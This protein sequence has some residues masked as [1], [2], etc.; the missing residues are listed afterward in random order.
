MEVSAGVIT[1]GEITPEE[2]GLPTSAVSAVAGGT[3]QENAA[4]T[5]SILG[6]AAG[7]ARDLAL[8]NAGAAVY[9]AGRA[10]SVADGV[11]TAAAAVDSGAA[12]DTLERYVALSQELGA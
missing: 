6:G 4:T 3:P 11:T 2:A 8:L 9:V 1:R 10:D 12:L 7:A 5:R